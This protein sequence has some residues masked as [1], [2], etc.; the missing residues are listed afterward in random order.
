MSAKE[1]N[2]KIQAGDEVEVLYQRM[3]D[4][5]FA[6][7]LVGDEVFVGSIS[8]E[9]LEE[10]KTEAAQALAARKRQKLIREAGNS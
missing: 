1:M 9:E 6:F 5:W 3:G 10:P 7:S 8:P 2:K 4:R